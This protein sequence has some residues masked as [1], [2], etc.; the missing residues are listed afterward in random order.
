M[1]IGSPS[2]DVGPGPR[3]S[4]PAFAA[5]HA[6]GASGRQIHASPRFRAH[7]LLR[8]VYPR[9]MSSTAL[10]P[11]ARSSRSR[12]PWLSLGRLRALSYYATA[13]GAG[14]RDLRVDFLRGFCVFAM[15]VDHLGGDSWLYALT[16]GNRFYVSAA[17]GFIF[18]SGLVM[19]QAYHARVERHGLVDAM[20]EAMRR[21]RT[22]YVTTVVMTLIFSGLYLF[23]DVSLWTGRDFGLGIEAVD[24]IVVGALTLHY[25]YHGTDILAM[26]ALLVMAAPLAFLLL[27][28]G[29]WQYVLLPSWLWWAAYQ[30]YPEQAGAP[31]YIRH[32]ENFPFAAW[33]VLFVTGLVLGYKRADVTLRLRRWPTLWVFMV[34]LCV[35]AT[36]VLVSLFLRSEA[37]VETPAIPLPFGLFD[38]TPDALSE[39]F[40]KVSLRPW[41]LAAFA[42]FS[43]F[44]FT[45][46]TYLWRPVRRLTGWFFLPLGSHA[47]YCYVV[48]FFLI[49]LA[50]NLAPGIIAAELHERVPTLIDTGLQL[51]VIAILWLMVRYRV[52][53]RVVPN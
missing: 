1:P 18:I 38:T 40:F 17:E 3:P 35:A 39:R 26:Y 46:V 52:L 13:E 45:A 10:A 12:A 32:A 22:L 37:G 33:Q 4:I 28:I 29:R 20:V 48:H 31:W 24:E 7:N 9:C 19:G 16:G 14:R 42:A 49:V 51:A 23:T 30:F 21:A 2:G 34:G 50:F 5:G 41:R 15:V 43:I 44:A 8:N 53:F 25:T 47:L 27:S 6:S 36:L 11:P